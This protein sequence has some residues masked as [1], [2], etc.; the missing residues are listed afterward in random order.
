MSRGLGWQSAL[1]ARPLCR[2]PVAK[3]VAVSAGGASLKSVKKTLSEV[4]SLTSLCP[5]F[6]SLHVLRFFCFSAFFILHK[7]LLSCAPPSPGP[8]AL[9]GATAQP[10]TDS[11]AGPRNRTEKTRGEGKSKREKLLSPTNPLSADNCNACLEIAS[12][13]GSVLVPETTGAGRGGEVGGTEE[14]MSAD[15]ARLWGRPG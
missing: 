8:G 11:S 12:E 1:W 9:P 3:R 15:R 14:L 10:G 4:E 7:A 5:L 2:G 13:G 6:P